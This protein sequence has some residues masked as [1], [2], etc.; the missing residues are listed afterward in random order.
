VKSTGG[1]RIVTKEW[2]EQC[3]RKRTRFPWRRFALD[4]AEQEHS[5]SEEE[6][7]ELVPGKSYSSLRKPSHFEGCNFLLL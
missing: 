4:N 7:L 6:I 3:F 5:E 1:G 2:L